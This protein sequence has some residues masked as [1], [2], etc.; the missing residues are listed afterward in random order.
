MIYEM[1]ATEPDQFPVPDRPSEEEP[2]FYEEEL[3]SI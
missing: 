3:E 2:E 1:G